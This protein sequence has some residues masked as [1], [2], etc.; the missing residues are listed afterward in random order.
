MHDRKCGV[1]EVATDLT[2]KVLVAD[3][4]RVASETLVV[5]VEDAPVGRVALEE[6]A[7]KRKE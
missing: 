1:H 4:Q 3:A 5:S 2:W 6:A 7:S